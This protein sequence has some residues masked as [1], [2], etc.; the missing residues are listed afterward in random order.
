MRPSIPFNAL[1]GS[2]IRQKK[3][4]G[5]GCP[6]SFVRT[7]LPRGENGFVI[8]LLVERER[9]LGGTDGARPPGFKEATLIVSAPRTAEQMLARAREVML[10]VLEHSDPWP[11]LDEWKRIL[12]IWFVAACVDDRVVQTCILDRW[13]LRA[14][15]HWLR[16]ENRR[17]YWWA[18]EAPDPSTLKVTVLAGQ[19]DFLRGSL[20]WL[21]K[22]G[23]EAAEAAEADRPTGPR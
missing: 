1:P 4:G 18:A 15:L 10:A 17:W 11:D 13:S 19:E 22:A 6:P 9:V 8:G 12:P 5:Y 16:P 3:V 21:L 14:W 2:T 20:D 7:S 23:S